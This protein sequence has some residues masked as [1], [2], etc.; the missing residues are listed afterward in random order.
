MPKILI[1]K[2]HTIL[3]LLI[4]LT[5]SFHLGAQPFKEVTVEM[6]IETAEA[7]MEIP[8]YYTALEWYENAYKEEKNPDVA[9]KIADLQIK[10]RDFLRAE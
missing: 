8:D 5:V 10:I 9:M 1:M 2:L 6:M 4:G 7:S 3:A